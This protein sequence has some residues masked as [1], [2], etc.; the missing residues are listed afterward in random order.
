MALLL[1]KR[2]QT[3]EILKDK[4]LKDEYKMGSLLTIRKL[5]EELNVSNSPI[6]EA[7]NM[8]EKEGLVVITSNTS[9]RVVELCKEDMFEIAQMVFFWI[10]GA[11]RYCVHTH[12]TKG[13]LAGMDE[14]ISAQKKAI[15]A[16]DR[17]EYL[18]QSVY[19]IRSVIAA[20]ENRRLLTQFENV[21]ALYYLCNRYSLTTLQSFRNN[22]EYN[23]Q[24]TEHIRDHKY[25][26]AL[27]MFAQLFYKDDWD[28]G[29]V[30]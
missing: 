7:L 15:D 11:F 25:T 27:D 26:E 8:L 22:T 28:G 24:I 29:R 30:L 3:Y 5:S 9:L 12:R 17:P 4:I 19:F 21:Y 23:I 13:M 16:D 6:R 20:T 1:N 2:E 14:A 10:A 18:K